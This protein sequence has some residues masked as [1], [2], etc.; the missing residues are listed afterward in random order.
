E[1]ISE[2]YHILRSNFQGLDQLCVHQRILSINHTLSFAF[3][4]NIN[5]LY[6][7]INR[8]RGCQPPSTSLTFEFQLESPLG[9]YIRRCRLHVSNLEFDAVSDLS[10]R[11][12]SFCTIEGSKKS[13]RALKGVVTPSP[14]SQR[15]LIGLDTFGTNHFDGEEDGLDD[16][17]RSYLTFTDTYAP[18]Y[19]QASI[20][21]RRFYDNRCSMKSI[22]PGPSS[23]KEASIR[24]NIN[25]LNHQ[26]ALLSLALFHYYSQA[27]SL[28]N[29]ELQEATRLARLAGDRKVLDQCTCLARRMAFFSGLNDSVTDSA[30]R[31]HPTLSGPLHAQATLQSFR[32][33]EEPLK[34]DKPNSRTTVGPASEWLY[35]DPNEEIFSAYK[36]LSGAEP[37]NRIYGK[38]FRAL[39]MTTPNLEVSDL[40]ER[41]FQP[42]KFDWVAWFGLQAKVW[43]LQG[44]TGLCEL[45]E[46]M[47]LNFDE[48]NG[49]DSL[50]KLFTKSDI[51]CQRAKRFAKNGHFTEALIVLL[52]EIQLD[53]SWHQSFQLLHHTAFE[54]LELKAKHED[55][56]DTLQTIQAL[57]VQYFDPDQSSN[58]VRKHIEDLYRSARKLMTSGNEDMA[59]PLIA[60][61]ITYSEKMNTKAIQATGITL[62][63]ESI[64][65]FEPG[66]APRWILNKFDEQ[67]IFDVPGFKS[68]LKSFG[69][70]LLIR[71]R[72]LIFRSFSEG[73]NYQNHEGEKLSIREEDV[74]EILDLLMMIKIR[75]IFF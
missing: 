34:N 9:L 55:D 67:R 28:A 54:I 5:G 64:I 72:C 20:A 22:L 29:H 33:L 47:A 70:A 60:S 3:Q 6:D 52:E 7:F 26:Q 14:G 37:I 57:R 23:L 44:Q 24:G 4:G 8:T 56:E 35:W 39:R 58:C 74:N 48:N 46:D 36:E 51:I 32:N 71:A 73:N 27:Y 25:G 1:S 18:D 30:A 16:I 66:S 13:S 38:L 10:K 69:Q 12:K 19:N 63:A 17:T 31:G 62:W 11:L 65:S 68:D 42:E 49:L 61:A 75:K 41:Q 45:Y 59:L 40:F 2:F 43:D 53:R 15:H 21:L 50:P